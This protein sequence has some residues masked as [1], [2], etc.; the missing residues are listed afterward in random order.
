MVP[1]LRKSMN[2]RYECSMPCPLHSFARFGDR[3]RVE[4]EAHEGVAGRKDVPPLQ[5]VDQ[6]IGQ[7][8]NELG[9]VTERRDPEG[10]ALAEYEC[11]EFLG[12]ELHE[13]VP[14]PFLG[15]ATRADT[16][17]VCSDRVLET[18]LALDDVVPNFDRCRRREP[19]G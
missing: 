4:L 3:T 15:R 12:H 9:L 16:E 6:R 5:L 13:E 1:P 10:L 14:R 19:R 8:E 2:A 18:I 7:C 17:L 11:G